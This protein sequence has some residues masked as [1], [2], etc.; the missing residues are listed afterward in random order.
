M[1]LIFK[2]DSGIKAVLA[3][4]G[5]YGAKEENDKDDKSLCVSTV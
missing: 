3:K 1:I 4:R 2:R 5:N